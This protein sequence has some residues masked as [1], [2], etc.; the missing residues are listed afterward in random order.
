MPYSDKILD[1]Y[2]H[3]RN[4]GAFVAYGYREEPVLIVTT[5]SP[6]NMPSK[7]ACSIARPT[8]P[9][10]GTGT[11]ATLTEIRQPGPIAI[12]RAGA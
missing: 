3:P 7:P 12:S 6:R 8:S 10:M 4:V 2:N 9:S 11:S 5:W 1:H